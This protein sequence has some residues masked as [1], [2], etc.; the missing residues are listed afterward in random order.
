MRLN[1]QMAT[2]FDAANPDELVDQF[3]KVTK[4]FKLSS[5]ASRE[6]ADAINYLDDNAISKGTEIIGFMNRVSGISGI[7][8]ITE[9]NMAALG[10]TLQTAGAAEEQSATAVNAIFTRLS[11]ASKKKPV[12]NALAAMGLSASKVELGMAKDAQGTLMKI[13]ETVK[14]MPKH[15]RLGFIADLVGTE[16]TKT[17]A[18]L[19]SNTEEWRRQI[20][21]ANSE[22]AKGSM[23]REFETRMKALSSTWGIFKNQIFNLNSTIGGTLA[24]TLDSLMKKIGGLIDKGNKW[25]QAHP[26]LAKN[27]LLVTGANR[28]IAHCVWRTRFRTKFCALSYCT[29]ISRG[30]QTQHPFTEIRRAN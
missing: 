22:T 29:L 30:K 27:M 12:R 7:A 21:L 17:L 26:K 19:V 2:A 11:S 18:L 1:T 5:E 24:P 23:G 3:G 6:L 4:N 20:E 28:W 14:K 16:H 8:K 13:V 25:I 10:S 15:K 9:K